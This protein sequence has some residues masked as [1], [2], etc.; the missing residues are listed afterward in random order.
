MRKPLQ[1]GAAL[2]VLFV[3]GYLFFARR[4]DV[5]SAQAHEL[6]EGGALLL[7]VRTPAEFAA[8]H[9]PKAVNVPVQELEQRM[10]EIGPKDWPIVVYCRSGHRS[11]R[12]G[13][14]LKTAGY[15][16]VHDLGAMSSW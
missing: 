8:G 13:G 3:L 12:A 4:G 15:S 16:A 5:S 9:L 2:L 7:D 10:T 1:L 14:L 6:V 11:S